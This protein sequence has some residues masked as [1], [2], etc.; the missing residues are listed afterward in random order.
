MAQT[1]VENNIVAAGAQITVIE[2][3]G[4]PI[5]A[6]SKQGM[7]FFHTIA[8][9]V[10][11]YAIFAQDPNGLILSWN[12]G[13]RVILGY[14]ENEFVGRHVSVIFTPEDIENGVV[15]DQMHEASVKGKA[16]D[17]KWHV[18]RDGSMFWANGLLMPLA[19]GSD[20]PR[21]YA[22][23]L[24]DDT[25]QK[26]FED[27]RDGILA[28][29]QA[30]RHQAE[31]LRLSLERAKRE[32][33]EFLALLAHELRNPLNA[34]LGWLMI[35]R[36]GRTDERL[37]AKGLETI[38]RSARSQHRMI[39]DV[40]DLSRITSGN[41]RLNT[42]PM[43]LNVAVDQAIE[44]IRPAA[45]AK[46]I[47]IE[48]ETNTECISILGDP[49]RIKQAIINILANAV[50]FTSN[51]GHVL[52]DLV[53]SESTAQII[54]EDNGQGF[55]ADF[56]P[57]IFDRYAQANKDSTKGRSGLG[58]GLPL[59]REIVE[60]HGGKVTAESA[61]EGRGATFTIYL[62]VIGANS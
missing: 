20:K 61:G 17:R 32:E 23:I 11:D 34:I 40:F 29:E 59:V 13:V 45:Q 31:S 42:E 19:G 35:L 15:D 28:R 50:K 51:G 46:N 8:E 57:C 12:L 5:P 55:T 36:K 1:E 56:L 26:T 24:R 30:A 60:Q 39:E 52:V 47:S 27:E 37:L 44:S 38:E 10:R 54:V 18:R 62:P 4:T 6:A 22:R 58:L 53:S 33:E 21:G 16:K 41:L 9:N 14:D 2:K 43:S 25:E 49:D 48:T 7:E 3:D